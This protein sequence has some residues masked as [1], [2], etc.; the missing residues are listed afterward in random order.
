MNIRFIKKISF[1]LPLIAATCAYAQIETILCPS[2][3]TIQ[4][5]A[6]KIDKAVK[7]SG[8]FSAFT[9]TDAFVENGISWTVGANRIMASSYAEAIQKGINIVSQTT[10]REHE[11]ARE[12][13]TE[14]VQYSCTYGTVEN[15][16]QIYALGFRR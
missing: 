12:I 2:I 8:A 13:P 4:K 3:D 16:A 7:F 6:T 5:A 11:D 1:S 14:P 10:F 9:S 15:L